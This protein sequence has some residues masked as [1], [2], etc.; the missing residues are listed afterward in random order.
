MNYLSNN[1]LSEICNRLGKSNLINT[2]QIYGGCIHDSWRIEFKDAR[3]FLKKN[4]RNQKLLKFESYCLNDLQKYI[5]R[6]ILITP[7]VITYFVFENNEYLLMEWI[8]MK[9]FN[10]KNLGRGLAEMHL[11]SYE[12]HPPKFGYSIEGYIGTSK[13]MEGWEKDWSE[14]FVRLRIEPQLT[15][16][17]NYS[18]EEDLIKKLKS[19]IKIHLSNHEPMNSLVH[20]DLWSGNVGSGNQEKGIIFDPSC[21]W[22]DSEVDIAM[23]RLFGGFENNFYDQYYELIQKKNG[24]NQR[25]IIYNFYH[26]LNHANMFGGGYNKQVN[27]YIEKI[28]KM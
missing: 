16:L 15:Y 14:C 20:G 22:A 12:N 10:Q 17:K 2:Q 4:I 23:T 11:K 25:T 28:L 5:N 8:D 6:S 18:V 24:S 26:I 9:N 21:W 1:E 19:K 7:R 27:E 13:Q 3:F